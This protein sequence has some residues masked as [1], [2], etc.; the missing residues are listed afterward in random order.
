M[1]SGT[2][3]SRQTLGMSPGCLVK[4]SSCRSGFLWCFNWCTMS[5]AFQMQIFTHAKVLSFHC[6]VHVLE[7]IYL[8]IYLYK[9][10]CN[11]MAFL[12]MLFNFFYFFSTPFQQFWRVFITSIIVD[13]LPKRCART[14]SHKAWQDKTW[15]ASPLEIQWQVFKFQCLDALG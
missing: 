7:Y 12:P 4:V 10:W 8:Y 3:K 13:T 6:C 1:C 9:C 5:S 2:I 15:K 11:W 14:Q